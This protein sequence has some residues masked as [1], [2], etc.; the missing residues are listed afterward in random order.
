[1]LL[2]TIRGGDRGGPGVEEDGP[3]IGVAMV[4]DVSTLYAGRPGLLGTVRLLRRALVMT[5]LAEIAEQAT[6]F[7]ADWVANKAAA[8]L[9]AVPFK[10]WVMAY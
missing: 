7:V 5:V 3:R 2:T 9:M 6:E 4:V 1:M 8:K 10:G